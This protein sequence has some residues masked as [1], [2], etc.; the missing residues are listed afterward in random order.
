MIFASQYVFNLGYHDLEA[1]T[2]N[3]TL[4]I[5]HT[6]AAVPNLWIATLRGVAID[7]HW[8]RHW[9]SDIKKNPRTIAHPQC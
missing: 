9:S 2:K 8:G 7:F 5:C 4:Q 6:I 3:I 1:S